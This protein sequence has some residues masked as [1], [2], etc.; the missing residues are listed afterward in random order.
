[1]PVHPSYR[2]RARLVHTQALKA[3][4]LPRLTSLF[5]FQSANTIGL[6][7]DLLP[8]SDPYYTLKLPFGVGT[9]I[10]YSDT[11]TQLVKYKREQYIR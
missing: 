9:A 10:Q 2:A 6:L 1:V 11:I 7:P 3:S 4:H 5:K 8:F